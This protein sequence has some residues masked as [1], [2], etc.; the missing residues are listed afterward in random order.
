MAAEE[1]TRNRKP[2]SNKLSGGRLRVIMPSPGMDRG[3]LR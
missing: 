2:V 3:T 1:M